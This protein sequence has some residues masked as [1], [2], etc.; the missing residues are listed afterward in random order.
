MP[1]GLFAWEAGAGVYA[2]AMTFWTLPMKGLPVKDRRSSL[3]LPAGFSEVGDP[4]KLGWAC[5]V[6]AEALGDVAKGLFAAAGVLWGDVLS[7]TFW[8]CTKIEGPINMK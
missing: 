5:A 1:K 6:L 4:N 2:V 7:L 3:G 8:S